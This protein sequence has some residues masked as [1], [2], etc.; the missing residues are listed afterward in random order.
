MR[1]CRKG[2]CPAN[3]ARPPGSPSNSFKIFSPHPVTFSPILR[4]HKSFSGNTY[5]SPRKCCKQKTYGRPKFISCNTYKK[6]GGGGYSPLF[7]FNLKPSISRSL[8]PCLFLPN[9]FYLS[10]FH[11]QRR[12]R[13]KSSRN[14]ATRLPG[15]LRLQYRPQSDRAE[16]PVARSVQRL[17]WLGD[18]AAHAHPSRLARHAPSVFVRVFSGTLRRSHHIPRLAHG[19]S[20][21][22]RRAAGRLR[23]LFLAAANRR[24]RNGVS[25]TKSAL[26]LGHRCL[27][28]RSDHR[29]PG[30]PGN[31]NHYLASISAHVA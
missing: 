29:V 22:D 6:Q 15:P 23:Q 27:A 28:P 2:G 13:S 21:A 7:S 19:F 20:G 4:P 26:L 30:R 3:H 10:G 18:V 31:R 16:L 5:G 11:G 1:P 17:S 8:R 25:Q 14:A 9:V 12:Q 24:A